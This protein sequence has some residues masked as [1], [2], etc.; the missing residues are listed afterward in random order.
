[1]AERAAD[2]WPHGDKLRLRAVRGA[3]SKD[4]AR[5]PGKRA[6]LQRRR[7]RELYRR[8]AERA[9]DQG[10]GSLLPGDLLQLGGFL[11]LARSAHVRDA[12]AFARGQGA[13]IQGGRVG[14]QLA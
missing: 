3:G 11:E 10:R 5:A 12:A 2:I 7:R 8:G 1:M 14:A 4:A 13:A 6:A 9:P